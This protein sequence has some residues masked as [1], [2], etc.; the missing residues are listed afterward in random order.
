MNEYGKWMRDQQ[1][2]SELQEEIDSIMDEKA[3]EYASMGNV[4]A[5]AECHG[6]DKSVEELDYDDARDA[7]LTAIERHFKVDRDDVD[8]TGRSDF[9]GFTCE[10]YD[11]MCRNDWVKHEGEST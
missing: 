9:T 5:E 11:Y 6:S 10:L 4:D 8:Q 2:D 1:M 3:D 7:V